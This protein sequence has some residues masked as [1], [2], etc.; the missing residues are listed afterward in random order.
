VVNRVLGAIVSKEKPLEPV[1]YTGTLAKVTIPIRNDGGTGEI[2]YTLDG[3]RCCSG[4]RSDDGKGI[5]KGA[6][7]V[8]VRYDKG[9][10][11][12]AAFD[13]LNLQTPTTITH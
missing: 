13:D 1:N 5:D 9:I 10:A 2:V 4:A 7:V 6:E 11:Y 3:A 12:V 8:I